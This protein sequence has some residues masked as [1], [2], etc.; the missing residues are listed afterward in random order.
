MTII[1]SDFS[2]SQKITKKHEFYEITAE[3]ANSCNK[4]DT[5]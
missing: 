2:A 5:R 1:S 4:D 3:T